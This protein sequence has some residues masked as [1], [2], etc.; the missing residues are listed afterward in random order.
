MSKRSLGL[1][2]AG[3]WGKNLARNFNALEALHTICD[4]SEAILEKNRELY[5]EI[6]LTTRFE[7]MLENPEIDK[8]AIAAPAL[9]HYDLTKRALLSNKDVYV[10]KPLC[11][12]S[13]EGEELVA[14]A[15]SRGRILMVGHILHYHPCVKKMHELVGT[16]EIGKLQYITSN[17]LNLGS[18]RIEENAL[19]NFAPHDI[20]VILSLCGYILP[21]SVRCVGADYLSH[22][23]ADTTLTTLKFP[24]NVR[25]HIYVSW[26]NPFKEQKLTVV[27]SNGM[28]VFD[29][30]KPWGEKL[31]LY[32][33]HVRWTHGGRPMAN[34]EEPEKIDPP[35]EEPLRNECQH[36]LQC[37]QERI[38]PQTDGVEGLHVLQV[39]QAAQDSLDEDGEAHSPAENHAITLEGVRKPIHPTAV[40]DQGAEIASDVQVWHFSHIMGETKID[41]GSKIGQNVFIGSKVNLG[42]NVKVQNNVSIYSGVTCE[43]DVFLGPSMV[44]T[45]ILNPRCEFPRRDQYLPTLVKKGATVGANATVLCGNTIGQY[46]F[47]GAGAVVT[48]D[49]KPFALMLGNPAKQVGWMSRFGKRLDL[50][51]SSDQAV[52]AKCEETN[53]V[54]ELNGE[55]LACHELGAACPVQ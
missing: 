48:K 53:D 30:T 7:E 5:P 19:W 15:E 6:R 20:S 40:V 23:V 28:L 18:Y 27:G 33:N 46:A 34:V 12:D 25:A 31:L 21:E 37:C 43:D 11:M 55:T 3:Y 8:I 29:D 54:Y 1:I 36:F 26:L 22:G 47:V 16:G 44:F 45:N 35:Q 49:V 24:G 39:L 41:Q 51:L 17:R 2:G 4:V 38:K 32:R 52:Q 50:P 14:L 10:E 13:A 9:Q 42:K